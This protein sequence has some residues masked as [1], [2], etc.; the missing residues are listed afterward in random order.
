[1]DFDLI[2]HYSRKKILFYMAEK[3][4]DS[5][6]KDVERLDMDVFNQQIKTGSYYGKLPVSD[7]QLSIM[8][9]LAERGKYYPYFGAT[10]MTGLNGYE[11]IFQI[12]EIIL[13][14]KHVIAHKP[15][16]VRIPKENFRINLEKWYQT[17]ALDNLKDGYLTLK[18]ENKPYNKLVRWSNWNQK[19][20]FSGRYSFFFAG[21]S[22]GKVIRVTDNQNQSTY[23]ISDYDTW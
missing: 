2:V 1:M 4:F 19:D 22:L 7:H 20:A 6:L 3:L 8:K 15:I 13:Q 21:T 18:I 9:K 5:V 10:S 16:K 14:A 23:D 17:S 12:N 11:I